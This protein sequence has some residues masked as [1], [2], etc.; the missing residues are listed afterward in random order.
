MTRSHLSRFYLAARCRGFD[1]RD[2]LHYALSRNTQNLMRR[3]Q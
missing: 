1:Y 3:F 2:S